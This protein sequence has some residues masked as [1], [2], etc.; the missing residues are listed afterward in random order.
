MQQVVSNDKNAYT[1][2][3]F[4]IIIST[5]VEELKDVLIKTRVD[6]SSY[7]NN[8]KA[9]FSE[10]Y[11]EKS[12]TIR[13]FST[14]CIL[15]V[16]SLVLIKHYICPKVDK[17]DSFN[18]VNSSLNTLLTYLNNNKKKY[19]L[20]SF[21]YFDFILSGVNQTSVKVNGLLKDIFISLET[22]VSRISIA[23]E[24]I[25]PTIIQKILSNNILHQIGEYYTP[26]VLVTEMV[27]HSYCFGKRVLDPS[28][29]AGNF[30]IHIIKL[31]LKDNKSQKQKIKA[32]DAIW[33]IDINP[34]A[35]FFAKVSILIVLPEN[36]SG[37]TINLYCA[38]SLKP[39]SLKI[40][41]K[42]D[43]VLGNPPWLTLRDIYSPSIQFKLKSLA[44]DL[45]IK[46]SPK[47]ILNL[48][49]S[50]LFFYQCSK[51]YLKEGGVIFFVITKGIINGSHTSKFRNFRGFSNIKIWQF[52]KKSEK[53][54]NIDFVCLYA[55][56]SEN[57]I[58]HPIIEIPT[59]QYYLK[60][61]VEKNSKVNKRLELKSKDI[62][63]P[64][65]VEGN[66][67]QRRV[68]KFIL[69]REL[70]TLVPNEVSYYKSLFHK[71]A[72]LNP[73]NL[74][75]VVPK[76]LDK[77]RVKLTTDPRV[78]KRA[79]Y[80]WKVPIF[81]GEILEKEY[82]YKAIK[83]T[84]LLHFHILDYYTVFLPLE[85]INLDFNYDTLKK[86]GKSCY[87]MVNK[88][89]LKLKKRTTKHQSLMENLNRW[90]KL[91]NK[92]Q[93]A[94]I[95]VVYNNSG[96]LLKSAVVEGNYVITGD[97]S[98]YDTENKDE[99]FYLSAI[100]NSTFLTKQVQIRKSSRHIFKLPFEVPISKFDASNLNHIRLSELGR[101]GHEIAQKIVTTK[102]G[103]GEPQTIAKWLK[104]LKQNLKSL[105]NL[106]DDALRRDLKIH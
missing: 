91:I 92:R 31:I 39:S 22:I 87:D 68:K 56:K 97:L 46:P 24:N 41:H 58:N 30:L 61:V 27:Q 88:I 63:V 21:S 11:Q 16:V 54:F 52:D 7:F 84:E 44:E 18:S 10:I 60:E 71:G 17:T 42:F 70:M 86:Y 8:W 15:F 59:F 45:K 100:L 79:K 103:S 25:L 72:D 90:S 5:C 43:I 93:N 75:F 20:N 32:I 69:K 105:L 19:G 34:I 2:S 81:S 104:I 101:K 98:Y 50:T 1:L 89:Y 85:R 12:L 76:P 29:G 36:L 82:L 62:L 80:P 77:N 96:S 78:L 66:G 33:G 38:N 83:S 73:R 74:I 4:L 48:E 94:K 102:K 51:A 35:I 106:I 67:F 95:K 13:L 53:L 26:P 57:E 9:D 3:N 99:A 23:P 37:R 6:K 64:Y 14:F 49:V 65:S 55:E 40:K 28:C 47:N